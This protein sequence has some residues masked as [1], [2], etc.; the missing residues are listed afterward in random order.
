MINYKDFEPGEEGTYYKTHDVDEEIKKK[1]GVVFKKYVDTRKQQTIDD[2]TNVYYSTK[3]PFIPHFKGYSRGIKYVPALYYIIKKDEN[4]ECS[5]ELVELKGYYFE[6]ATGELINFNKKKKPKVG[7][8]GGR[9]SLKYTLN[10]KISD[11][12]IDITIHIMFIVSLYPYFKW[13]FFFQNKGK[14]GSVS[15]DHLLGPGNHYKRCHPNLLEVVSV[16]ENSSRTGHFNITRSVESK[17]KHSETNSKSVFIKKNGVDVTYNN[18][19]IIEYKNA[20]ECAKVIYKGNAIGE[21]RETKINSLSYRINE[22]L[23]GDIK[24]I[25]DYTEYTFVRGK[26][27]IKSQEDLYITKWRLDIINNKYVIEKYIVKEKWTY[28]EELDD[29]RKKEIKALFKDN[30]IPIAISDCGR[31]MN[32]YMEKSYGKWGKSQRRYNYHA[33]Y[34]IMWYWF[35]SIDDIKKLQRGIQDGLQLCHCDGNLKHPLVKRQSENREENSNIWETFYLG[36]DVS[37]GNDNSDNQLRKAQETKKGHFKAFKDGKQVGDKNFV[38][39]KDFNNWAKNNGYQ[40]EFIHI[41]QI[42]RGERR[43]ERGLTFKKL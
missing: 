9:I 22:Y 13:I 31:V 35:A 37:N 1:N 12:Q 25:K 27:Y 24:K 14:G 28:Y 19:D 39:A 34:T 5:F 43:I 42:L 32:Q 33:I 38:S 2:P 29:E 11:E 36:D 20:K 16:S 40:K 41:P 3:Y 6:I 15:V 4:G 21:K 7:G 26:S 18:E 10:G 23:R 17:N 30:K 8:K